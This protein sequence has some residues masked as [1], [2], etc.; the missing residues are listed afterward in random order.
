MERYGT[1]FEDIW[2]DI[3]RSFKIYGA[4]WN[5]VEDIWSE[6]SSASLRRWVYLYTTLYVRNNK[7]YTLK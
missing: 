4:I 7:L 2:S 6:R 5:G 3:E 1:E